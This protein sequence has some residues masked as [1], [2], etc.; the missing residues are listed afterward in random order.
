MKRTHELNRK[1]LH[2][3]HG[4]RDFIKV[5][6]VNRIG[7]PVPAPLPTATGFAEVVGFEFSLKKGLVVKKHFEPTAG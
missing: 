4:G 1:E 2:Q 3:I 6:Y 7:E 5:K